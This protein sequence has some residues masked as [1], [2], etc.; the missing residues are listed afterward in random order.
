MA[1]AFKNA[2]MESTVKPTRVLLVDDHEANILIAGTYLEKFGYAYDVAPNGLEAISKAGSGDYFAALMDIQ[3]PTMDGIEATRHI[4]NAEIMN[5]RPRLPIIAFTAH[6]LVADRERCMLAGMDEYLTKP[7]NPE[8]MEKLL[9][10]L[11][12]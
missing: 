8:H 5:D 3:M 4:R 11:A 10:Q 9:R 2:S 6:Y 12:S 7:F 1:M